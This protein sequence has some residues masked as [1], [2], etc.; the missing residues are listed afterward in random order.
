MNGGFGTGL[1][2]ATPFGSRFDIALLIEAVALKF[3]FEDRIL[4]FNY[5]DRTMLIEFEDRLL[6]LR[7][8]ERQ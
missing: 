8:G 7:F 4:L 5:D 2:G 6:L 3:E 1:Y